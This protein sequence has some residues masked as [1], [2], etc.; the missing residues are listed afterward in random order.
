M[1]Q[2]T[3]SVSLPHVNN[4][5]TPKNTQQKAK[6]AQPVVLVNNNIPSPPSERKDRGTITPKSNTGTILEHLIT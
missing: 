3:S 2:K 6:M 4:Q 5:A 1:L